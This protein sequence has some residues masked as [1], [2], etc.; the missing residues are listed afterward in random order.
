MCPHTISAFST[1]VPHCGSSSCHIP[2]FSSAATSEKCAPSSW[3]SSPCVFPVEYGSCQRII[4]WPEGTNQFNTC[5]RRSNAISY[6][7]LYSGRSGD[8]LGINISEFL[9]LFLW[10]RAS[11]YLTNREENNKTQQGIR[12][13]HNHDEDLLCDRFNFPQRR[14]LDRHGKSVR[15]RHVGIYIKRYIFVQFAHFNKESLYSTR[16]RRGNRFTQAA[17]STRIQSGVSIRPQYLDSRNTT[18]L[19]GQYFWIARSCPTPPLGQKPQTTTSLSSLSWTRVRQRRARVT[20]VRGFAVPQKI[21]NYN[22]R[23]IL[24][25]L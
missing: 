18:V 1:A 17:F 9:P 23:N 3:P 10:C 4:R 8:C 6:C 7:S 22:I 13:R 12:N 11:L 19:V 21:Y 2:S 15:R 25:S 5:A 14:L 20:E 16:E 24:T